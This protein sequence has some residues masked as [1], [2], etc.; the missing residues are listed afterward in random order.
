MSNDYIEKRK[1]GN[2]EPLGVSL[3][4]KDTRKIQTSLAWKEII[5][6]P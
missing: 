6:D 5:D 3:S 4:K 2:G 1:N